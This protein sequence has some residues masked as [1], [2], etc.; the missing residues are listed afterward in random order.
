MKKSSRLQNRN[1]PERALLRDLRR[2]ARLTGRRLVTGAV[3]QRH[4]AFGISTL[5]SR[6]G[7]WNAALAARRPRRDAALEGAGSR[8]D[9][10]PRRRVAQARPPAGLRRAHHGKWHLEIRGRHLPQAV[11]LVAQSARRVRGLR[12][13]GQPRHR[14]SA[15]PAEGW[16]PQVPQRRL[17]PAGHRADPRQLPLPHVRRRPGDGSR[18]AAA[19]RSHR[20]VVERR[21]DGAVQPPDPV[22]HV[23]SRCK[24]DT[25]HRQVSKRAPPR[26]RTAHDQRRGRRRR[27]KGK[28]TCPPPTRPTASSSS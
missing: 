8:D 9:A 20:A 6:F 26:Y 10:E 5:I 12:P 18:R 13:D 24:G 16:T 17:P 22:R 1:T 21:R 4:G 11:R 3:Y 25:L 27:N 19:C 23:Q 15:E 2:V 28:K 7:S 14:R